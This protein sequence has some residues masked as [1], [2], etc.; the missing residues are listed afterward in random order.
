[1]NKKHKDSVYSLEYIEKI[2]RTIPI[3][4]IL[5]LSIVSIFT[6]FA[7]LESKQKSDITLIEQKEILK[8]Q[9]EKKGILLHFEN[10]VKNSI[11]EELNDI[12]KT[13]QEHTYKII[14]S[15]DSGFSN[16]K[17]DA[18]IKFL[19][20]YEKN[21][22]VDIVF[23]NESGLNILY[24]NDKI[25]YLSKLIFGKD[26]ITYKELVLK[27][28]Y[29]QGRYN[30]Q[31]WKNDLTGVLKLSF[32]DTLNKNDETYYIGVF[33]KDEN[34]RLITKDMIIEQIKKSNNYHIWFLDLINKLTYNFNNKNLQENVDILTSKNITNKKYDVLEHFELNEEMDEKFSKTTIYNSKYK[35]A[36]SI[37]YDENIK[38]NIQQIKERYHSLFISISIYI[39]LATLVLIISS[40]IFSKIT[41]RIL[42][43]YNQELQDK[44]DS[45]T[46]WKNRF[47]LAIIASNDGL[48]DIDF[49]SDKIYFSDKWLEISGYEKGEI[50]GFSDWFALIHQD[51]KD[52]VEQIFEQIFAGKQ[53]DFMCEYRLR[54]KNEGFKW[55]LARGRLFKESGRKRMLMMSMDIDKS[56]R[57]KKELLDIE[58]LVEDG[59]IVL[60]KLFND[61]NLSVK[62][63][64]N[65]IKNYGYS[66]ELFENKKMNFL[67]LISK[68]DINIVKVAMNEALSKDLGD[69][70]FVCR[71]LNAENETRWISCRTLVLKDYSGNVVNFY[72]YINDITKIKLSEQEL[73]VKV[74]DEVSKNR[75]KDRI[76]IQ[77]SKLAAMGEMLGNIAHQWRQPLNG[78]GLYLQFIRDN[79]K[80]ES[81]EELISKYFDKAA[82]QIHY[83]SDTIDDF[84]NFYKPSKE[85][86]RFR[87]KDAI[88][89]S[90][91]IIKAQL[92]NENIELI[93]DIEDVDLLNFENELK[94][95]LLNIFNNAKDAIILKIQKEE[96]DGHIKVKTQLTSEYLEIYIENNGGHINED[97]IEKIFEPYFTTKFE[98]QG[99]GIGLYMTKSI[100]ESNMGGKIMVKNIDNDSV[101]FNISLAL[102]IKE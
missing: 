68:E 88:E 29:S 15:L 35:F 94:Q 21:N 65:A 74:E 43:K 70:T 87:I 11:S 17:S 38:V 24:G 14:G 40:F 95:A 85:R 53:N 12:N 90:L 44:T 73:K 48:W 80:D 50:L 42:D 59:K 72:G 76:L 102:A 92:K 93:L 84:R 69:F 8:N 27:Y 71:A 96:F 9:F 77:Q 100:I 83:M 31:E 2:I 5:F 62:F 82:T 19:S 16:I 61:E 10:L 39:I 28:I 20:T 26:D 78:V 1:M 98:S 79:Y 18:V 46:H 47:E 60:F 67:D 75:E 23:F 58:L 51:D 22:K 33:S 41:K 57:M 91:E 64:S 55:I 52:K 25:E 56:M 66:K 13:L 7:I 6:T 45:L 63:I 36:I 37:D 86:A 32:F 54:T 97:I 34:M 99:T 4:F 30:L 101:S 3:S 81:N 49:D 89:S